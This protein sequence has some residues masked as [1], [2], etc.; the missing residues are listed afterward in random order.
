ME[1]AFSSTEHFCL[2]LKEGRVYTSNKNHSGIVLIFRGSSPS[3]VE[4][5]L[6][7]HL[8]SSEKQSLCDLRVQGRAVLGPRTRRMKSRLITCV[9]CDVAFRQ[10]CYQQV[11]SGYCLFLFNIFAGRCGAHLFLSYSKGVYTVKCKCHI[12]QKEQVKNI[13]YYYHYLLS[14]NFG[15]PRP[16]PTYLVHCGHIPKYAHAHALL[17]QIHSL[18]SR[19]TSALEI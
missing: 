10:C 8:V 18:V 4:T 14:I 13:Y 19:P 3:L 1:L 2:W 12:F 5:Q 11:P 16:R 9:I 15:G 6:L 7:T 17:L